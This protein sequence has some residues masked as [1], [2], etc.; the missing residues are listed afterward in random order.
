MRYTAL[1]CKLLCAYIYIHTVQAIWKRQAGADRGRTKRRTSREEQTE[2]R[3][4]KR[5]KKR[6]R[7]ILC[8]V[9]VYNTMRLEGPSG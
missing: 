8:I 4:E 3:W 5:A 7:D 2:Q 9:L 1:Y 6:R